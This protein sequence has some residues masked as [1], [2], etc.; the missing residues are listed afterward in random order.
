MRNRS[1]LF[2]LIF[3]A[4]LSFTTILTL[5]IF[6][7]KNDYEVKN[8][9]MFNRYEI[10]RSVMLNAKQNMTHVEFD[11]LLSQ[12]QMSV[13]FKKQEKEQILKAAQLI[14][15]E[16]RRLITQI[17]LVSPRP[18]ISRQEIELDIMM[19][20]NQKEIYF[21]LRT[22][23]S[24]LLILDRSLK[25]YT[26][27]LGAYAFMVIILILLLTFGFI[28]FKLYPL[29]KIS[30]GI[31]KFGNG[32]LDVRLDFKGNDELAEIAKSFNKSVSQ[33]ASLI[34]GRTLF[35]R[36]VMHELKTPI[37]KG[38]ILAGLLETEQDRDRFDKVFLRLQKLI[39]DFALLDQV[40]SN[41]NISTS[42]IYNI[43]DIVDEAIEIGFYEEKEVAVIEQNSLQC[44]LDYNLFVIVIKN[45][46][47]NGI[48]YS[49]DSKVKV[50]IEEDTV[51]VISNGERLKEDLSFY[52][53]AFVGEKRKNSFGLGLY[54]VNAILERHSIS[55]KYHYEHGSNKFIID[56][57]SLLEK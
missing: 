44:Y 35:M 26:Y 2:S 38:R 53:E 54:I 52:L 18:F 27:T 47:D 30:K 36:N 56:C 45:L 23:M 42:E 12:F 34:D 17:Y 15:K 49:S 7:L 4:I 32:D 46:L 57:K 19:L 14:N 8:S 25:P 55:L 1:L 20:E 43:R 21:Y 3:A 31:A 50:L 13:I 33:I 11:H 48:K 29:K 22:P 16:R 39:D 9:S 6:F 41:V 28:L 37:A 40:K 10:I 51:S 24:D 5:F